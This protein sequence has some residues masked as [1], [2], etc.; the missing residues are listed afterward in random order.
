MDRVTTAIAEADRAARHPTLL[1]RT[2]VLVAAAELVGVWAVPADVPGKPEV[3]LS[4]G[5]RHGCIS[6]G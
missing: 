6:N 3:Q 2:F 5:C 4:E 1:T